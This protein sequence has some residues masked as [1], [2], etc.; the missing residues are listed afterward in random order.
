NV[1][2]MQITVRPCVLVMAAGNLVDAREFAGGCDERRDARFVSMKPLPQTD[3][4]SFR[5]NHGPARTC[6]YGRPLGIEQPGT[7]HLPGHPLVGS[8]KHA[9]TSAR[10]GQEPVPKPID[11][12]SA[13]A[14][15]LDKYLYAIVDAL[16]NLIHTNTIHQPGKASLQSVNHR[17]YTLY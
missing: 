1:V 16:L 6:S 13:G 14:A 17:R 4:A 8:D 2:E 12:T 3:A 11:N 15:S 7:I 10:Q 9:D 5:N